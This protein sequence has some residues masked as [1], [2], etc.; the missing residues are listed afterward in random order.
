M[1]DAAIKTQLATGSVKML[2]LLEIGFTPALRLTNAEHDVVYGGN[3]YLTWPSIDVTAPKED[4]GGGVTVTLPDDG[5][6]DALERTND[7]GGKTMTVTRLYSTAS[8]LKTVEEWSGIIENYDSDNHSRCVFRADAPHLLRVG[9]AMPTWSDVCINDFK[10]ARCGYAGAT[11]SCNGTW[12]ACAA[13][14]GGTNTSNFVAANKAPT[15][16]DIVVLGG[17]R[18]TV[19]GYQ[20]PPPSVP[21][22]QPPWTPTATRQHQPIAPLQEE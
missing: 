10:S 3:R 8:G 17:Q 20:P 18:Y 19:G 11:A 12:A 9:P 13:M 14:A 2:W 16:G 1:V 6:I 15:P 21:P 7:S 5:T 4:Q 22:G